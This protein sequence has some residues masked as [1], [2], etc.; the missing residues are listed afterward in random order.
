MI[1]VKE[2]WKILIVIKIIRKK[3]IVL[4]IKPIEIKYFDH[5]K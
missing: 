3:Q 2:E 5:T 1:L 4:R